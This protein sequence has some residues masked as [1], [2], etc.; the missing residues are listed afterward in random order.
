[1]DFRLFICNFDKLFDDF[2]FFDN[3]GFWIDFCY[4]LIYFF[5]NKLKNKIKYFLKIG[6]YCFIVFKK[7]NFFDIG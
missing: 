2:Y 5:I 4:N 7:I 3:V 1:M 6:L